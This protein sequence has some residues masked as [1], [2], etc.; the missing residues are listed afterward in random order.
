MRPPP[1]RYKVV[2]RG[3]RLEVVDTWSGERVSSPS[4]RPLAGGG[5]VGDIGDGPRDLSSPP[6]PA[7]SSGRGATTG[8]AGL[9]SD[10]FVTR[11]WYDDKAP[12]T[13]RLNYSNRARLTNVRYGIAVAV[14]VLVAL[15]FMFWPFAVILVLAVTLNPK[16][17]TQLRAGITSWIDGFDQA[18]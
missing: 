4:P 8:G 1:T 12:R 2:E 7:P 10:T 17:R 6:S 9:D 16:L 5:R 13:I 14:A 3:R 11:G 15:A 18:A